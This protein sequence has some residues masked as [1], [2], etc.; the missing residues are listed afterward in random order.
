MSPRPH[1][2][3]SGTRVRGRPVQTSHQIDGP[4]VFSGMS[5]ATMPVEAARVLQMPS[6]MSLA[7]AMASSSHQEE[8][9]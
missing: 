7:A 6:C 4:F 1:V 3:V 8:V 5:R 9:Q 2:H